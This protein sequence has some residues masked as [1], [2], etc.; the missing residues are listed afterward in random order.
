MKKNRILSLALAV[1]VLMSLI[2]L[3]ASASVAAA[4]PSP[5]AVEYMNEANMAGLLTASAARNFQAPLTRLEF[6]ELVVEMVERTLGRELPIPATNPFVD[7]NDIT[8][9]K[10]F[11][12]GRVEGV[13]PGITNGI[14]ATRFAPDDFVER[15]QIATMMIRAIRQLERDTGRTLLAPA[16]QTLPFHDNA[17]IA[18]WALESVRFAHANLILVGDHMGNLNPEANITS[19]E[20]VTVILRSFN[21]MEAALAV[22]RNV[23][24]L[25]DI[26]MRR[27][28]I[29]FAYGD[30]A[31]GVTRNILLPRTGVGDATIS[32]TSSHPAIINTDG[33]VNVTN[34]PQNVTLTAT[35]ALGGQTRT[36]QFVLRTSQFTGERLMIENALAAI[37][38]IYINEGDNANSVTGRIALPTRVMGIPVT[39]TTS[40]AAVITTTGVVFVPTGNETRSATLT[41]T[42]TYG[43]QT[44]TRSFTLTVVNPAHAAGAGVALHGV[45]IDMTPQQVTQALGTVRNTL[46]TGGNESWQFFH[47]NHSNFIAVGF[48]N[49]RVAAVYSMHPQA[50]NNLRNDANAVITVAQANA[51]SGLTVT[52]HVD[53]AQQYAIMMINSASP[54]AARR[55]LTADGQERILHELVNAYRVRNGQP[56]LQLSTRLA[57]PARAHSTWM[58]QSNTVGLGTGANALTARAANAGFTLPAAGTVNFFGGGN[59]GGGHYDVFGFLQQMVSANATRNELLSNTATLFGAG[60]ATTTTGNYRTFFTYMLG[61]VRHITA[62]ASPQVTGNPAMI[63]LSAGAGLRQQITLNLTY[64][65][66]IAGTALNEPFTVTSSNT[67]IMRVFSGATTTTPTLEGVANGNANLIITGN[68]SGTTFEIPVNVGLTI[69]NTL[70][71]TVPGLGVNLTQQTG[72]A[73]GT[74]ANQN[75]ARRLVVGINENLTINAVTNGGVTV[76]WRRVAGTAA[77]VDRSGGTN[78]AVVTATGAAGSVT[79]EARVPT[80]ANTWITHTIVVDVVSMTF[81]PASPRP[82]VLNPN[83]TIPGFAAV[84]QGAGTV[85]APTTYTWT[86]AHANVLVIAPNATNPAQPTITGH[87]GVTTA[88]TTT[89]TGTANWNNAQVFGSARHQMNVRVEP[90]GVPVTGIAITGHSPTATVGVPMNLGITFTPANAS[91]RNITWT[92]DNPAVATVVGTV[93]GANVGATVT[94]HSAGLVMITATSVDNPTAVQSVAINVQPAPISVISIAIIGH[95]PTATVGIPMPLAVTFNPANATNQDVTWKSSDDTIATVVGGMVTFLS[96]GPVVITATSVDNLAAVSSVPINVVLP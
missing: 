93:V 10:A 49:N 45:R 66:R 82:F 24:E 95:S 17:Q 36:A 48:I 35:V 8:V 59:V 76:D 21:Q 43:G 88:T 64:Y 68:L 31:A 89:L 90:G 11:A 12:Y 22:G 3:G 69:G 40:N 5:W 57:T 94:F 27:L 79:L 50:A 38:I 83:A 23:Q 29:G 75:G 16:T 30:S 60:F 14:S 81:N 56:I 18:D 62:V 4:P 20:C 7:T 55:T 91:N 39:W 37:D 42:I 44:R 70:T 26:N 32:W 28:S 67:N 87:S 2:P 25:L 47:T 6:S 19:E 78:N 34:A 86:A 13:R 46:N 15:Q 54:I 52:A 9:L 72:V 51:V 84:L 65:T 53:T 63:R 77:N 61:N 1:V 41:A 33:V 85:G 96:P 73:A 71:L 80:G 92:T 74:N 58:M